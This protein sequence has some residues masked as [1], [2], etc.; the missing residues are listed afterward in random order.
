MKLFLKLCLCILALAQFTKAFAADPGIYCLDNAT[1]QWN[2]LTNNT[3]EMTRLVN[4]GGQ[5]FPS[6]G[7]DNNNRNDRFYSLT[8]AFVQCRNSMEDNADYQLQLTQ[9]ARLN[10]AQDYS[11]AFLSSTNAVAYVYRNNR[12][13]NTFDPRSNVPAAG[14]PIIFQM[15][16]P[17]RNSLGTVLITPALAIYQVVNSQVV[18][19]G[20]YL[21]NI[22][23]SVLRN[24]VVQNNQQL[25]VRLVTTN[26]LI[27]QPETC[28]VN[29]GQPLEVDLGTIAE[30]EIPVGS[31][32][33]SNLTR[34]IDLNYQCDTNINSAMRVQLVGEP[35]DFSTTAVETRSG[36]VYGTGATI[37]HLGIEFYKD[38]TVLAPNS[39]NGFMTQITNGVGS[40]TLT[41][42]PV[43]SAQANAVNLPSGYFNATATLVFTTP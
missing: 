21:G 1:G 40:D 14:G 27:F 42:A 15:Q 28:V 10:N 33:N 17:P 41:I 11:P 23:F 18:P 4:V 2:R 26:D 5:I 29:N 25:V 38:T 24:G 35:S 16:L 19:A 8:P 36:N 20:T 34:T 31:G 32:L 7:I 13:A 30:V 12:N 3:P 6:A 43:K 37:Q 22:T 39:V 9:V